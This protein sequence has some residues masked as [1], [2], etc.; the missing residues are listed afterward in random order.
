MAKRATFLAL[1]FFLLLLPI[2]WL[3]DMALK[4]NEDILGAFTFWPHHPT[5]A[6]FITVLTEPGW[7]NG[8]IVSMVR[9]SIIALT[10][11]GPGRKIP[12]SGRS[13]PHHEHR[14]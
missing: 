12:C 4:T 10:R 3:V 6:N 14:E 13:H 8:F 11:P 2:Y 9:A 5:L 1:Y 7:Y